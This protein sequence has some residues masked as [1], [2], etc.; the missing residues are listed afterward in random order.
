MVS[1]AAFKI[2]PRPGSSESNPVT[3]V[4]TSTTLL[5]IFAPSAIVCPSVAVAPFNAVFKPPSKSPSDKSEAT[6]CKPSLKLPTKLD[7]NSST[8]STVPPTSGSEVRCQSMGWLMY[9]LF[10]PPC[11]QHWLQSQ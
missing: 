8:D 2:S 11:P 3:G 5:R 4:V 7:F 9:L 10:Q 1:P 6:L